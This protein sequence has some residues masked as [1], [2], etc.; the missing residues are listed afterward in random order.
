MWIEWEKSSSRRV[1]K[2]FVSIRTNGTISFSRSARRQW[3]LD[4]YP[5]ASLC[6]NAVTREVGVRFYN[7]EYRGHY[8]R[9]WLSNSKKAQSV[10]AR[11]FLDHWGILYDK[12]RRYPVREENGLYVFRP[13]LLADVEAAEEGSASCVMSKNGVSCPTEPRELSSPRRSVTH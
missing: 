12:C 4:E 8:I 5:W 6:F 13:L 2:P 10:A 7:D 1:V 9:N 3:S 11:Q